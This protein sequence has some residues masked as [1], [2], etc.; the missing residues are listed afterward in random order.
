MCEEENGVCE[1][2]SAFAGVY[3]IFMDNV[4]YEQW[5]DYLCGLLKMFGAPDGLLLELGCGTGTMT[6]LLAE[7][8]YDMIGVDDSEDMLAQAR[9]K[10]G[11]GILYLEQD[12]RQFELYGT[13]KAVVSV[14]DCMNYILEPKDLLKVFSLVNNYLDPGGV[15]I[16]DMNT[17]HKY[18]DLLGR[19]TIAEDRED[20][21]FIWDNSYSSS[22]R[23]NEY[24]LTLFIREKGDIFRRYQEVHRQ[25]A[26]SVEEV[27]SLLEQ[28]GLKLMGV[29]D[30]FSMEKPDKDSERVFFAA[31][32]CTKARE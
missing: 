2:Y 27:C 8:G 1:A 13:V 15:F 4:P 29:Y 16:F 18:R 17:I 10:S 28:A 11:P 31:Q 25:K 20:C 6:R 14:C 30:A 23:I 26:Y 3:D 9:S 19:R 21:S 5:C 24:D 7:R 32:E 22:D 12:M